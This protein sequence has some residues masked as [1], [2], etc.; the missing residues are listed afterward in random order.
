MAEQQILARMFFKNGNT[1]TRP[2]SWIIFATAEGFGKDAG[3]YL[4]EPLS[5]VKSEADEVYVAFA[6]QLNGIQLFRGVFVNA[7]YERKAN[8]NPR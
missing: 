8:R 3:S 5:R 2:L 6:D 4:Q 1:E 7:R